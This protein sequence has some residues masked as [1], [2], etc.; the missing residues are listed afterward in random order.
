[1]NRYTEESTITRCSRPARKGSS[2]LAS[3]R[4]LRMGRPAKPSQDL[5]WSQCPLSV[6]LTRCPFSRNKIISKGSTKWPDR[7]NGTTVWNQECRLR[8][9]SRPAFCSR[10]TRDPSRWLHTSGTRARQW[11]VQRSHRCQNLLRL[12]QGSSALSQKRYSM[13]T[14][15]S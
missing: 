5:C 3:R 13:E 1:M 9:A 10:T 6:N 2:S 4:N 7:Q 12:I 11:Q 8:G 15:L 14:S